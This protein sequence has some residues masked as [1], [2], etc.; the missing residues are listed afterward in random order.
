MRPALR[1]G[2]KFVLATMWWVSNRVDGILAGPDVKLY[3]F[4]H[5][6]YGGST[7]YVVESSV[8]FDYQLRFAMSSSVIGGGRTSPSVTIASAEGGSPA[9][10]SSKG[11]PTIGGSTTGVYSEAKESSTQRF[12]W[13]TAALRRPT[14]LRWCKH[15][16][17]RGKALLSRPQNWCHL[18]ALRSV[19]PLGVWSEGYFPCWGPSGG[20]E[21]SYFSKVGQWHYLPF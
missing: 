4:D 5:A 17:P 1:N 8:E 10:A 18:G 3:L 21:S 19:N 14:S 13:I 20:T 15:L 2:S 9:N 16:Q 12:G 6:A 7:A 11:S